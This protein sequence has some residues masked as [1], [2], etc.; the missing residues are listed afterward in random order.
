[1]IFLYFGSRPFRKRFE[2]YNDEDQ[3]IIKKCKKVTHIVMS[4]YQ[5]KYLYIN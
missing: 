2:D 3:Y 4:K 5:I 1:M